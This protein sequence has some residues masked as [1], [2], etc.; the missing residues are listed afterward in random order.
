MDSSDL[1][2]RAKEHGVI[3]HR[4]YATDDDVMVIDEWPDAAS[5][6]RFFESMQSEIGPLMQKGL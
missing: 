2:D 4:F 6:N 1:S 5:F 3:A